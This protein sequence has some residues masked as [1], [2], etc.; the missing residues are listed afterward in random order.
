MA[1]RYE[2]VDAAAVRTPVPRLHKNPITTRNKIVVHTTIEHY[3]D[4]LAY[5][6][7]KLVEMMRCGMHLQAHANAKLLRINNERRADGYPAIRAY[8]CEHDMTGVYW[9]MYRLPDGSRSPFPFCNDFPDSS[10]FERLF[11]LKLIMPDP[12]TEA[13][14]T[15][16]FCEIWEMD[17][18]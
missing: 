7:A 5:C 15:T 9:V 4:E 16:R 6:S 2:D 18:D 1:Q 10:M 3:Q 17:E 8:I 11:K 14:K 13:H 12:F